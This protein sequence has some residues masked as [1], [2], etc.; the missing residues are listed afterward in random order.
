MSE[1]KSAEHYINS[2]VSVMAGFNAFVYGFGEPKNRDYGDK[3]QWYSELQ[4]YECA[5]K[6]AK[7]NG[8]P[9][10][11]VFKCRESRCHP[12]SY[13]GFFVCNDCGNSGV[14]KDWWKIQVE[15]DGSEFCCHGLDFINLQESSNYAFGKTF[16]DAIYNYEMLML[17]QYNK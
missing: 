1:L 15:K 4:G 17:K 3:T 16:E 9:F 2:S 14:D 12:F 5:K 10:T 7:N 6:M 8:I 13:G 11:S